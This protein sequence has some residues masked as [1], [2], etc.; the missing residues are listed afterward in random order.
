MAL[1]VLAS[2]TTVLADS[3]KDDA[4]WWI[5]NFGLVRVARV[6]QIF[7]RVAE[8][9]D[10]RG[11]K[12]P[13]I[14]SSREPWVVAIKD[15]S[16]ILTE[17]A[18][19]KC[20]LNV[21]PQKGEARLAFILGH[22]LSHFLKDDFWHIAAFDALEGYKT[23]KNNDEK[24]TSVI[25]SILE[26][27]GGIKPGENGN[28]VI[29]TKEMEADKEGL[30]TMTMAGFDPQLVVGDNSNFFQE[31][32]SL[33][34]GRTAYS[35]ATHPSP[36][37]RAVFVK[38]HMK[39]IIDNLWLFS[40]GVRYYQLGRYKDALAFFE[41]FKNVYAGR[42]VFNNIGLCHYQLAMDELAGFDLEARTRFRFAAILDGRT[43]A[44]SLRSRAGSRT[45]SS[46][47]SKFIQ[48][49]EAA[50]AMFQQA[51]TKDSHY[52]AAWL[53]LAA[54]YVMAE[55]AAALALGATE[56]ALNIDPANPD[57]LN[58]KA[59]ALYLVGNRYGADT[60]DNALA[61]LNEALRIDPAYVC[62][63]YNKGAIQSE[64]QRNAAALDSWQTFLTF[65]PVGLYAD[66]VRKALGVTPEQYRPIAHHVPLQPP[67]PLSKVKG[68][69]KEKLSRFHKTSFAIGELNGEIL[70]DH[71]TTVLVINGHIEFEEAPAVAKVSVEQFQKK[72]GEPLRQLK[73]TDGITLIYKNFAVDVLEGNVVKAAFFIGES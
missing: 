54:A 51:V 4:G 45:G 25:I 17:E 63:W 24:I 23:E 44:Q 50:T 47:D 62:A 55:D 58:V 26:K 68:E 18:I 59:V 31:W 19:N 20:F 16:V 2:W 10:K 3:P 13:R 61:L 66:R 12:L 28:E 71:D 43:R 42:E 56:A 5:K 7:K 32:L 39:S 65:E 11:T 37:E 34:T 57:A 38:A 60:T 73:A 9:A 64:R 6:E 49:L 53:N 35:D 33:I 46:V 15:G 67:I 8:A 30:L 48:H 41:K 52:S 29:R 27:E 72:H 69:V 22:E 40:F 14:K 21:S 36:A 70:R 1:L